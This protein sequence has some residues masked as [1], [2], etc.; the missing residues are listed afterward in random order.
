[1]ALKTSPEAREG[2]R[3]AIIGFATLLAIQFAAL[4][5]H[6]GQW[7]RVT[8]DHMGESCLMGFVALCNALYNFSARQIGPPFWIMY[9]IFLASWI[10][11][12]GQGIGHFIAP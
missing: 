9:V 4:L 11:L 2:M 10:Y 1:M 5:D 8:I 3:F 12:L 7:P 6:L